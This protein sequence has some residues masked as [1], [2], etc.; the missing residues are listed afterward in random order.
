M[1][2]QADWD[3][4]APHVLVNPT[5]TYDDL[6][7]GCPVAYSE[8]LGWSLFRHAD[9]LRVLHDT[10]TF[11]SVVSPHLAVP[12]GMDPPRHA[13]Y[14]RIVE[15]YFSPP[16]MAL[17]EPVCREI[18]RDLVERLPRP[19][20]TDMMADFAHHFALHAQCAFT[21]WPLEIRNR[22]HDWLTRSQAATL[23]EDRQAA[24][25]LAQEFEDIV[26]AQLELRRAAG[27]QAPDDPTTGLLRET[28]DGRPLSLQEITSILRNWTAGELATIA[29]SI[30]ILISSLAR[31]PALQDELRKAPA[32]LPAAIEEILR[33][34]C[35]LLT[36]RRKV[37]KNTVI[38]G[39]TLTAGERVTVIWG[40]AN[41]DETVFELPDEF[42]PDRDQHDNLLWGAGIHVCPGA[43]LA[44]MELKVVMECLLEGIPSWSLVSAERPTLAVL[45]ATGFAGLP[46]QLDCT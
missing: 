9:V 3:P 14:R 8:K 42:H 16:K 35:P 46:I 28:V 20:V 18:A 33:I 2:R 32:G 44:R 40:A 1:T 29:A 24:D 30:G 36:N 39:R 27:P 43:P 6:R 11:S 25:S 7:R 19:G 38:G 10:E 26:E 23:A 22:L 4:L 34:E 21:G 37:R 12:S 45:P 5:A 17:F 13:A 15:T 41:R 31:D